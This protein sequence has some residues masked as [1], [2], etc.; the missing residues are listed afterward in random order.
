MDKYDKDGPME[1]PILRC[2]ACN[3]II[4]KTYIRTMGM[5]PKCGNKRVKNVLILS[6]KEMEELRKT[7]TDPAFL[8][9]FEGGE[10]DDIPA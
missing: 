2:A 1:D 5:C 9:L 8:D 10:V 4:Y 6:E 3:G 7:N